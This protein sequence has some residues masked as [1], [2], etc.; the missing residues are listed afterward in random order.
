MTKGDNTT[1]AATTTDP[2]APVVNLDGSPVVTATEG[3]VKVTKV[4]D[5]FLL[6]A[7][8]DDVTYRLQGDDEKAIRA[9]F[10]AF[11]E[12]CIIGR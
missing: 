7:R 12:K 5:M 10:K 11:P 1:P 3:E 4:G 6:E 8:K 9:Y 2:N